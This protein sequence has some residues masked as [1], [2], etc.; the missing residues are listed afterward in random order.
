MRRELPVLGRLVGRKHGND[1]SRSI[2]HLQIGNEI[3]KLLD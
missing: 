1:A 2:D 3:A